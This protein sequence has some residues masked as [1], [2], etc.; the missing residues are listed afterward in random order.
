MLEM[1]STLQEDPAITPSRLVSSVNEMLNQNEEVVQYSLTM[2]NNILDINKM[3]TESFQIQN[4]AF[5]LTDLM[6]RATTMQLV[7]AQARGV[8][9]SF[10]PPS[11]RCIAYTDKDIVLRIVTNFISVS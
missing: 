8:N 2:L 10:E 5:D 9:M 3:K 4:K 6:Q 7:K 1:T 11:T